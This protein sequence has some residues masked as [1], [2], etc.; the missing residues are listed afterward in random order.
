MNEEAWIAA[1]RANPHCLQTMGAFADWLQERDDPRWEPLMLLY[2]NGKVG[3]RFGYTYNVGRQSCVGIS[4]LDD[5]VMDRLSRNSPAYWDCVDNRLL[6]MRSWA[7]ADDERR[8]QYLKDFHD[9]HSRV[10]V[11]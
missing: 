7:E 11:A 9:A 1:M 3:Y 2:N 10:E 4:W 6:L 5:A 8:S